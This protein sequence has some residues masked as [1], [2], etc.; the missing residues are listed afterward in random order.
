MLRVISTDPTPDVHTL[1]INQSPQ[2]LNVQRAPAHPINLIFG[3]TNAQTFVTD[4][5][6]PQTLVLDTQPQTLA[7]GTQTR[8]LVLGT[9]QTLAIGTTQTLVLGTP[10][11]L[12]LGQPQTQ[13]LIVGGVAGV[14]GVVYPTADAY[15]QYDP[16]TH[17]YMKP[18]MY[19][20]GDERMRRDEWLFDTQNRR[21]VNSNIDFT[22]GCERLYLEIL[23]NASDN[24]GR[25]RRAGVDPGRIEIIMNN[26]TISVTNYGLPIPVEIHPKEGV[27][28]PQM[29]FGSLLTSSNYEV[30]RHEAGT[31]GIGAKAAN[32]FSTEFMVIVN[33]HIRHLKYTQIWNANMSQCG[34]PLIE[35]YNGGISSVQIVYTMDFARF[36][37]PIPNGDQGGYPLEAFALFARHAV[38]ISFTSK[39]TVL[40]NGNEFNFANIR[41]YAR[42]YFGDAVDSAII[43]YQWPPGIEIIKKKKGF[44]VAKNLGVTP[45]IELIAIDTPDEGHHVSFVNCMM[46]RDGGVHVNAG[47]KAVGDSAVQMINEN[48]LKKLIKQNKG[49]ELDAKEK[50]AHTITI[51]DV[52]PHI[53]I[54][55]SAKVTNPKFTSQTKTMLHSPAPKIEVAEEEL[56]AMNRW[57]LIDRLYAALEAKQFASMA[58]TDGKLKRYVRLLKGVD[59]NNA[60]KADRHRCVLYV[61]EGRSGAGYAN[62]LLGLVPGGRD[63]I[64]VLPMRGKSLNV[65]NADRIQIEGNMEIKE[66]KKMLGLREG[67]DYLDPK[68]FDKLRYGALMIMADSDVDGK[69]IIGL[70]LNFFH[71]R[72]PS[73]LAR[74]FVMHYRTPTIRVTFNRNVMKFYTQREYEDWRDRTPNYQNWKH[75]YFKGLGSSKKEDVSDD[76][77]TP[78]VVTCFY[79]EQAPQAMRLAFDKKFA[80]QRKDWI[81][82]W[83]P[84]LGTDEV[85]MQPI[86]WFINHELILF[87][88]ADIQRSIPKLTDGLKESHRK[89][90]HAAHLKWKIGSK[91]KQYNECKVAQFGAFVADKSKYHHGETILDDV[92][93]GMAQDYVGSN[94]VP[95]FTKGGMFGCVDPETPI[96]LWNGST[97]LA[98]NI[99]KE[100]ILIGDDG[101]PR[102]IS[103]IVRGIDDMYTINQVYGSPYKVN[104]QHILTLHFPKHKSIYWKESTK[105]WTMEYFDAQSN[106]IKSKSTNAAKSSKEDAKRELDEFAMAIPDDNIF[107]INLQTYLSYPPNRR[108]LLRSVRN[109]NSINWSKREVPIDPYIFGMWLGD[110]LKNGRGFASADHELVK[111]WVKWTDKIGVEVVHNRNVPG[112]QYGFRRRG[113]SVD[114]GEQIAVG[115]KDHSSKICPGCVTSDKL[116]PACDWIYEEKDNTINRVY[117]STTVD[118]SIRDDMNPFVNI[119]KQYGLHKNKHIPE[120]YIINDTEIRLQLL[121]GLIDTDGSLKYKD[122]EFSEVFVISQEINTHGHIIDVAEYIAK[123]LGFKTV[124][125]INNSKNS[126]MKV[127]HINGDIYRIPTKLPRKQ[128]IKTVCKEHIGSK[129]TIEHSGKGEY[130]GW[131][132]DG[133]ERFL[134]GD[135]TVTHNTRYQGGKDAAETRYSYTQPERLVSYI[136]RKEDRP[137]LQH[138]IDEGEK[139]EPDTFYPVIP[140]ILANGGQGIGTGYSTFIPPHDPI[141][142]IKWLRLKLQGTA[143]KDLPFILPWYRGFHGVIKVIDRRSRRKR[144]A[145]INITII[146]NVDENG[147]VTPQV[148]NMVAEDEP[149]NTKESIPGEEDEEYDGKEFNDGSR[150]LLSMITLGKFHMDFNGTIIITELPIGRWPHNYHKW[151]EGLVEEKKITGFRDCSVEDSVYFEIYGFTDTPNYRTLKLQ[152]SMGMSNMVLLDETGRPVRYDTAFEILEAFYSRRLPIYQRRKNYIIENLTIEVVVLNH[153]IQFIRAV[154]NKEIRVMNRKKAEIMEHMDRL[155]IPRELLNTTKISNCTEDEIVAL[156]AQIEAKEM[157]RTIMEQTTPENIW[158]RELDELED[159]YRTVYGLKKQG[160]T[161]TLGTPTQTGINLN[162]IQPI[163]PATLQDNPFETVQARQPAH[164]IVLAVNPATLPVTKSNPNLKLILKAVMPERSMFLNI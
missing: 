96:L 25:S 30:D 47:V 153:K 45:E 64:G 34:E 55:L 156:N 146:N 75:K 4:T 67:F 60:G 95:W 163:D 36:K 27:Y 83:R 103:K 131:Y 1:A 157:E 48:V 44:Q 22:P 142:I 129:V 158:L 17:V 112:Y 2:T 50:R 69:H 41:E 134:L 159:V 118:G 12:V 70:I 19:I 71:C 92:V 52:K 43:H 130:I 144:G 10:Q 86:S 98:Q 106:K 8:T 59:A 11:T 39:T 91:N 73:L 13:T 49:K 24:V 61:T 40:F 132:I 72:F 66:L 26:S 28:V 85:Q 81:G 140:M 77:I 162:V 74:G 148:H 16:R 31:N 79:D 33:D 7:L 154:I 110:G 111:E 135:F 114:I 119:L 152:R 93:V 46:T 136:L 38:D 82:R 99:I 88:I 150:P 116:H 35:H 42:L 160:L 87:S 145:K 29:I 94:N 120:L 137:V 143:D 127:L 76:Y 56:R 84:V 117:D 9:P 54:L 65:M 125:S 105:R 23:T 115:H 21:M 53:S 97:K 58:K 32:I 122:R 5:P 141:E 138:L 107:D 124:V 89:I 51:N 121:A 151:L 18:D 63:Y 14:N 80:D 126:I 57:Q 133:N 102:Y 78:K 155:G 108:E 3:G 62:T 101:N 139:V 6:K 90:L 109:I 123:S 20:G 104:S 161:L 37:Y 68:N 113:A 147:M 100:D 164:G 149:E 128:A 15:K